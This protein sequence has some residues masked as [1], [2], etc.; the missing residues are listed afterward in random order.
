MTPEQHARDCFP[1]ECVGIIV[2]DSYIPLKNIHSDPLNHFRVDPDVVLQY[3]NKIERVLH[4]HN[5]EIHPKHPS[6]D[7]MVT[8]LSWNITFGI[9]PIDSQSVYPILYWGD[10]VS[11]GDYS[12]RDYIFGI[13]DCFSV[14][15]DY[16]RFELDILLP[17]FPRSLDYNTK[18]EYLDH[19][20]EYGF[21]QVTLDDLQKN[22]LILVKIRNDFPNHIIQYMGNH[23]GLHHL[24]NKYSKTENITDFID[25]NKTFLHSIW[26][27]SNFNK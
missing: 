2:N 9:I 1:Y 8:Q 4:S 7:D 25:P 10:D 17:N 21:Y 16:Y 23:Q 24:L 3:M 12:G 6:Y 14:I 13:Q 15:R 22:D 11:V 20:K 18:N 5:I 26:R 19:I 27:H